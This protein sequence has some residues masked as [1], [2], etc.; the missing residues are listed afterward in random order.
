MTI[1]EDR[2]RVCEAGFALFISFTYVGAYMDTLV[3]HLLVG[4]LVL[5]RPLYK[6]LALNIDVEKTR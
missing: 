3:V 6:L 1:C 4:R 2:A 5:K